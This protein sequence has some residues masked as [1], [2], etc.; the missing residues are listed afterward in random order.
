M[1]RGQYQIRAEVKSVESKLTGLLNDRGFEK[2]SQGTVLVES[3]AVPQKH[4]F[5]GR[6][7]DRHPVTLIVDYEFYPITDKVGLGFE[8][9]SKQPRKVIFT[10]DAHRE[11]CRRF[12]KS[13]TDWCEKQK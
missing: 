10:H 7:S 4:V 6:L 3:S 9:I 5:Y 8:L 12:L 1:S 13:L 2:V 11:E